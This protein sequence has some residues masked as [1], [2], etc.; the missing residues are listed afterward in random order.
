MTAP[1]RRAGI[2]LLTVA[3]A[4]LLA[5]PGLSLEPALS[6]EAVDPA[7]AAGGTQ[8]DLTPVQRYGSCLTGHGEGDLLLLMD[9]SGSLKD[10]DPHAARVAAARYLLER[11]ARLAARSG[12]T[13][14]VGIAGFSDSFASSVSWQALD[15]TSLPTISE[16]VDEYRNRNGGNDTDYWWALEGSRRELAKQAHG[17]VD[18]CQAI[19]WFSDGKL[20]VAVPRTPWGRAHFPAEKPYA[21]G[22]DLSAPNA[23]QAVTEAATQALCEKGGLADQLRKS[24][25][26]VFGVGLA[27]DAA[28]D[29]DFDLMQSLTT[30]TDQAGGSCGAVTSPPPGVFSLA[31]DLDDMLWAFDELAGSGRT[32]TGDVHPFVVDSSISAVHVLGSSGVENVEAELT[33]PSG[34]VVSLARTP[35][36]AGRTLDLDGVHATYSWKTAHT[37]EMDLARPDAGVSTWTG[38]WQLRFVDPAAGSADPSSRSRIEISGD[39][40][41]SWSAAGTTT[42]HSGQVLSGIRFGLVNGAGTEVDPS[43]VPGAVTLSA[44]LLDPSGDEVAVT[45]GQEKPQIG[46]PVDLDLTHVEPGRATLRLTLLMTTADAVAPDGT[47][48]PGT[49]LQ[50]KS[51]SLPVEVRP[52][53]NYPSVA[54]VLDFGLNTGPVRK[55][56]QLKVSGP[57][58]VWFADLSKPTFT[59][60]PDG[61]GGLTLT[62]AGSPS[63]PAGCLEV[64]DGESRNLPVTLS[65]K[66]GGNGDV[67]GSVTVMAA[68]LGEVE[69]AIPVEVTVKATLVKPLKQIVYWPVFVATF[70]LGVG[71]PLGIA[72]ALKLAGARIPPR[73]LSS[74]RIRVTVDGGRVLRDGR[75]LSLR[76]DD[77]VT[78]VPLDQGGSRRLSVD[79]VELRTTA[80][81]SPFGPAHVVVSAPGLLVG[82]SE[83]VGTRRRGPEGETTLP[84]AVHNTWVLLHDR[85]GPADEADLL[86][87]VSADT[88]PT[89][90]E[91]LLESARGRVPAVLDDLRRRADGAGTGRPGDDDGTPP[92]SPF[93]P[94]TQTRPPAPQASSPFD[95]PDLTGEGR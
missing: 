60:T 12:T 79:G 28:S 25:I 85:K 80:G 27:P 11:L 70:L 52:P 71:I 13:I 24:G 94:Q 51:V 1:A 77:F 15:P 95:F 32:T 73:P 82:S 6:V 29:A 75:P 7:P 48:T 62:S 20:D 89:Q 26:L 86:L 22:V 41:P 4:V 93:R 84:L 53:L 30:G 63:N 3:L 47:P 56:L 61:V 78:L 2:G 65:T 35:D 16:Q 88:S 81:L 46:T 14:N 5:V 69:Q 64:A 44:V 38:V 59:T 91:D 37:V 55:Q 87:L 74:R 42:L 39:L 43:T 36:G 21:A 19:A 67:N 92:P 66:E 18:R 68:P 17:A 10:T 9:E 33:L 57:G 31:R 49:T 34:R 72:Y 50:P 58:C 54:P 23:K 76:D 8:T 40:Q 90:R 83:P 45:P